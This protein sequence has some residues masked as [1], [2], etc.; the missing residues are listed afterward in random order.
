MILQSVP[1]AQLE[2]MIRVS[3]ILPSVLYV[4]EIKIKVNI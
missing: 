3:N 1:L 2:Y 4:C